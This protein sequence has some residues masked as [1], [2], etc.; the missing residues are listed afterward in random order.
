LEQ[1]NSIFK[2][3]YALVITSKVEEFLTTI[4]EAWASKC[5][6]VSSPLPSIVKLNE[7]LGQVIHITGGYDPK[8]FLSKIMYYYLSI[9]SGTRLSLHLK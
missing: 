1:C 7:L 5:P 3:A 6:V 2:N 9:S 8:E 4:L